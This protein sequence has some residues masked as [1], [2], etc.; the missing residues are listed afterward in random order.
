MHPR[1]GLTLPS[2]L[3]WSPAAGLIP[4]TFPETTLSVAAEEGFGSSRLGFK[5]SCVIFACFL[6]P[7]KAQV[8][9]CRRVGVMPPCNLH[10]ARHKGK[11]VSI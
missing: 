9:I 3:F 11:D 8:F 6:N 10:G 4:Q 1:A 7:S 5:P 2:L